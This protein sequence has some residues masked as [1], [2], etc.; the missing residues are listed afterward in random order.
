MVKDMAKNAFNDFRILLIYTNTS[1]EPLMPLGVGSI[2]TALRLAG[3]NVELFD[4]TF[5]EDER[6]DSQRAREYSLQIKPVDYSQVGVRSINRDP[7]EDFI[8]LVH[9]FKPHL[10]GLSCVEL[11]W[12]QGLKLLESV[13]EYK[14][15]NVV[16]GC[17]ATFSPDVVISNDIVDMICIGEGEI[18][19]VELA[20]KMSL[21]EQF[22]DIP[23]LW[24]K[25]NNAIYRS[26]M[27]DLI[28]LDLL[29]IPQFGIFAPERI[30]RAMAGKIYRMLPIEFSR[31]CPYKCTYCSAPSYAKK[32]SPVGRWLRF[33]SVSHIMDEIDFYIRENN[34]EYFYFVSESFLAMPP[35]YKN[36]FYRRYKKYQIPFWFNTRPETIN[37]NDISHLEDIGC[38]RIS[39][40]IE[41]G[42]EEFRKRVLKRDCSNKNI[43]KA[44]NIVLKSKIQLSVNNMIGFPDE[45]REMVFDTIELNREFKADNHSI[46]IFQPF[47]GTEL[48]DYCVAKGYWDPTNLC[49]ESFATPALEM[50]TLTKDE[51]KGLYRTFNL[52]VNAEKVFWN[53]IGKAEKLDEDGNKVFFELAQR[54]YSQSGMPVK[55]H[56]TK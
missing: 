28:E 26:K 34:V 54:F 22:I 30:Y 13:K 37:N 10:I 24:I 56:T 29:P 6:S 4:T 33:K 18:A 3:F 35:E 19:I 21:N 27:A 32:F 47:R 42:N 1:M 46:S 41:S 11:T 51:I 16:G 44:I 31:G 52:Y 43:L 14:I 15:P 38:N 7:V 23:N 8:E 9:D 45:T 2:A 48:Y 36:E 5:Y 49:S 17:F 25:R 12:P 40:G 20:K 55:S 39:I 53:D 50:P